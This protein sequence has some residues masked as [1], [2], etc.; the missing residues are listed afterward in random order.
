MNFFI[1]GS[2]RRGRKLLNFIEKIN[3]FLYQYVGYN[4]YNVIGFIDNNTS[5]NEFQ[6]YC[7]YHANDTI[8]RNENIVISTLKHEE[9]SSF[10]F[11]LGYIKDDNLFYYFEVVYSSLLYRHEKE[12]VN[13]C[14]DAAVSQ[15]L[16]EIIVKTQDHFNINVCKKIDRIIKDRFSINCVHQA[17]FIEAMIFAGIL[18]HDVDN[19][20]NITQKLLLLKS[21][22]NPV[23][24]IIIVRM[25]F[26]DDLQRA[27]SEID[28][29]SLKKSQRGDTRNI[30]FFYSRL[31]NGGIEKVLSLLTPI[32]ADS[33]YKII[34]IVQEATNNDYYIPDK[35]KVVKCRNEE[36]T[37]DWYY[38]IENVMIEN[39]IDVFCDHEYGDAPNAF[40]T[41]LFG[42]LQNRYAVCEIHNASMAFTRGKNSD[43]IVAM[44]KTFD[45]LV[46]LSTDDEAYWSSMGYKSK[47]IPNPVSKDY[48]AERTEI[49]SIDKDIQILWAGRIAQ[50]QK[51]VYD[52]VD[53]MKY[54]VEYIPDAVLTVIGTVSNKEDKDL[55][56]LKEKI[57]QK[58]LSNNIEFLGYIKDMRPYYLRTRVMLVTSAYEGFPMTV[59]EGK[60]CGVPICMYDLPYLELVKDSRGIN[61][62]AQRDFKTI[63]TNLVSVLMDDK[64]YDKLSNEAIASAEAFA[65][66]DV[67]DMWKNLFDEMSSRFE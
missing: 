59:A 14:F 56:C 8:W 17:D 54:V 28:I 55:D 45:R 38:E 15:D 57:I 47:Y 64:L 41:G 10:L 62:S 20:V 7:V 39:E 48:L 13:K 36:Y 60:S 33:G 35:I 49:K 6:G 42:L 34:L 27:V 51:Q 58:K 23:G 65:D 1:W 22:I 46:V 24:M 3:L 25:L 5:C 63:A 30:A 29:E 26:S 32:L 21:I 18:S 66:I 67:G 16:L 12:F 50:E 4:F 61:T 53:I 43:E 37:D 19:D 31:C 52:I 2:G 9:I 40:Y 11:G 44:Y